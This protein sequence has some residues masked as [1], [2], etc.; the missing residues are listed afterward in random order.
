M[1]EYRPTIGAITALP[2]EQAAVE[3][4]LGASQQGT[5]DSGGVRW[6]VVFGQLPAAD[7]T[8]QVI[9]AQSGMGNTNSATCATFLLSNF[10]QIEALIMV[11]IAGGVPYPV[12]EKTDRHVRLGDI[13]VSDGYGVVQYDSIKQ[14]ALPGEPGAQIEYRPL[15]RP[16]SAVLNLNASVPTSRRAG[17]AG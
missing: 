12:P 8:H 7:G 16:P 1:P 4:L 13:V 2:Q 10:S 15:P 5:I 11:G 9:V 3:A 14:E 6:P 17:A